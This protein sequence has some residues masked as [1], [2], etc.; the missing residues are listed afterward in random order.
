MTGRIIVVTGT[1]TEIGKTFVGCA[2]AG[3]LVRRG[4]SVCAIKPV[5]TGTDVELADH[6]DGVR[7]ANATG[8]ATPRAALQR[9]RK[10]LAPPDAADID[11]GNLDWDGWISAARKAAT[12]HDLVLVEGA[13]GLLSPLTWKHH[14]GDLARALNAE[15][16]VV[17]ADRL[18][19]QNHTRLVLLA[20][21]GMGLEALGVVLSAPERPDESTGRNAPVLERVVRDTRF[22]TVGRYDS[23]ADAV[24][25][26]TVCEWLGVSE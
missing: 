10:P 20:L 4:T 16:L 22:V 15:V 12:S 2:L 21:E 13:G 6:E 23:P 7:L 25:I 8:Q 18:G 1:D 11:G 3:E 24:E 14:A 19:T 9:F 5:E 26:G 17:A